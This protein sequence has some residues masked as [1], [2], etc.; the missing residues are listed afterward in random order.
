MQ[1]QS[2]V[3]LAA[4]DHSPDRLDYCSDRVF[5][6]AFAGLIQLIYKPLILICTTDLLGEKNTVS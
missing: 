6:Y 2:G 1:M 4:R 5:F 3:F